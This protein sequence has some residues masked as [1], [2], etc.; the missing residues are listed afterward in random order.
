MQNF[1]GNYI[2][3]GEKNLYLRIFGKGSPSVIIEPGF[4]SLSI[5]WAPIA[6]KLS[7]ETSVI[8]YDRAGYGESPK[9]K[10]PRTTKQICFELYD[11]LSNSG[12]IPPYI[13]VG[14]DFGGL[15]VQNFAKM[16]PRECAG[17]VLVN[18]MSVYNSEIE[19]LDLPVYN[20]K[21][22]TKS[23]MRRIKELIQMEK[24]DFEQY[25]SERL[26]EVYK[27]FPK[28]IAEMLISYQTDKKLY[29]TIIDEYEALDESIEMIKSITEFPNCPMTVMCRDYKV[30]SYLGSLLGIP[31]DESR[32]VEEVWLKHNKSLSE[33]STESSFQIVKNSNQMIH[34]SRPDAII[35]EI[36][37]IIKRVF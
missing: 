2:A 34:L 32:V 11:M 5:E 17:I 14:N 15:V 9:G 19:N 27:H 37:N 25:T 6:E 24:E 26:Q 23:S 33:L 31:E 7:M 13:M 20:E 21:S 18:S 35:Q 28:I 8:L 16:F 29:E 36:S 12:V 22:S 4:G 10:L 30:M 3:A 1:D